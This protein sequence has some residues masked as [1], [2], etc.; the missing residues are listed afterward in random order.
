MIVVSSFRTWESAVFIGHT[1]H[2][3]RTDNPFEIFKDGVNGW[4]P[5]CLYCVKNMCGIEHGSKG[6][7]IRT[8]GGN[9]FDSEAAE[10]DAELAR[11]DTSFLA[12]NQ[13]ATCRSSKYTKVI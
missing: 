8:G 12:T 10:R 13:S 11:S 7:L 4:V 1:K 5:K 3:A 9:A 6:L 2:L